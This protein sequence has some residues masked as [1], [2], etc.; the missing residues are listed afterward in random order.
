LAQKVRISIDQL[1][2]ILGW[3]SDKSTGD[4]DVEIEVSHSSGIGPSVVATVETGPG[5]GVFKDFTELDKW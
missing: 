1:R 5:E 3:A 2:S 4:F